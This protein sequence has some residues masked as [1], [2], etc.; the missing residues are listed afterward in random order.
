MFIWYYIYIIFWT[1]RFFG[2]RLHND[3]LTITSDGHDAAMI[4]IK[5]VQYILGAFPPRPHFWTKYNHFSI[6]LRLFS[7]IS[8][9]N[10]RHGRVGDAIS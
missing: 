10:Q 7:F 2:R 9:N 5:S 4:C 8:I 3:R 1:I 6:V